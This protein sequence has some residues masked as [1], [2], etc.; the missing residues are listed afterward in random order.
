MGSPHPCAGRK[1][2]AHPIHAQGTAKGRRGRAPATIATG[3]L[4]A[5]FPAEEEVT[6]VSEYSGFPEVPHEYPVSTPL[7]GRL[8]APFAVKV[9]AREQSA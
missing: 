4:A 9:E 2:W 7:T 1:E 6:R 3:G 5:P 8:A